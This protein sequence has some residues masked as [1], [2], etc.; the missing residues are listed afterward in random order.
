MKRSWIEVDLNI[1]QENVQAIRGAI[2]P[3]TELICVVKANAYGHGAVPVAQRAAQAGANWFAVAYL[4]E[5]LKLRAALP[6]VNLLVLGVVDPSDTELLLEH[7]VIP[8][9]ATEEHGMALALAARKFG[10]D[11]EAHIKIDTGMGRLGLPWERAPDMIRRLAKEPGLNITGMCSHF[12]KVEPAEPEAAGTQADRFFSIAKEAED[13]LG[14]RLF[15]HLSSSRAILYQKDWDLN[16]I[17]PG[18]I[19]YGYGT[20]KKDMRFRTR[21]ILQWKAFVMQVRSVPAGLPIGYYGTYKTRQPTDI[22]TLAVGYA[23]GY[24]R[25]L[26]NKGYVLVHG[27]RCPVVGRVS[28]NWIAVD[29]G[30]DSGVKRGDVAVLIGEQGNESV[31]ANELAQKCITIPYEILTGIDSSIRR[32]YIY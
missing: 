16:G 15:K 23:D 9:V 7:K 14:R 19:L 10:R 29:V 3:G 26:S 1:L 22:A 2:S 11:L 13:L 6:A 25:I 31:W 30:P 28:M 20:G 12:A 5:A 8:I 4:E 21:P 24:L 18:I 17:R 27:R 32:Q